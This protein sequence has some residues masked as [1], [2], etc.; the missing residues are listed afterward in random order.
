MKVMEFY[1]INSTATRVSRKK[2]EEAYPPNLTEITEYRREKFI[3]GESRCLRRFS[4]VKFLGFLVFFISLFYLPLAAL[5]RDENTLADRLAQEL[6]KAGFENVAVLQEEKELIVTYENRRYRDELAAA[7]EVVAA[8]FSLATAELNVTLIPQNRKIPL[9]ALRLT[10]NQGAQPA[11]GNVAAVGND[12]AADF[13]FDAAWKKLQALPR[14]NASTWKL[15]LVVHPQFNAK[16]ATYNNPVATQ[17]NL[18]PALNTSLWKGMSLLAQ[19]IIPLQNELG[20]KGDYAR[21]GLL[22][23]NQTLRLPQNILASASFGYFTANRYGL[24]MEAQKYFLNGKFSVGANWGYTGYASYFKGAWSYSPLAHQTMLL[25]SALRLPR[26]DLS[27][28]ATYGKF[29]YQD[30]AWRLELVRQFRETDFGFFVLRSEGELNTGFQFS[31]PIFPPKHLRAG[32]I[33]LRTA[34]RFPWEYR[35]KGFPD[36]GVIYDTG[37]NL[38]DFIKR[39]N[40]DYVRNQVHYYHRWE[41]LKIPR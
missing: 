8:I 7:K 29:L 38:D 18:A 19:I 22:V 41:D 33:R 12:L 15:D 30:T 9:V 13:D 36:S 5:S 32:R 16:F 4:A 3:F 24:D 40:P 2:R 37:N 14:A 11:N 28:R 1:L 27:L 20:K 35:Y 34:N 31:V 17:L 6:V 10:V 26:V 39:L 21:P 25:N 23:A